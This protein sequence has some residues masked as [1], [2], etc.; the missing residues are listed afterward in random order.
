[1]IPPPETSR[2]NPTV[3]VIVCR[4]STLLCMF[5]CVLS[6]LCS[7]S[8]PLCT[9]SLY[10][11][12]IMYVCVLSCHLPASKPFGV[13][14]LHI[15]LTYLCT[16]TTLFRPGFASFGPCSAAMGR[17]P[18][19]GFFGMTRAALLCHGF[20]DSIAFRSSHVSSNNQTAI[21]FLGR[22]LFTY[23]MLQP[24]LPGRLSITAVPLLLP[25]C[26]FFIPCLVIY[27]SFGMPK[28]N[29]ALFCRDNTGSLSVLTFLTLPPVPN[30]CMRVLIIYQ[31]NTTTRWSVISH[32]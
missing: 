6:G 23:Y 2:R 7:L 27:M 3:L 25:S 22:H 11:A 21:N 4:T 32:L 15:L 9:I 14:S 5:L 13:P 17:S 28:L 16:Y 31:P 24:S 10:S 20:L 1:M 26:F 30:T 8:P 29:F 12:G 18:S 19:I